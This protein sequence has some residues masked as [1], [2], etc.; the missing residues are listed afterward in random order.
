MKIR[1][2]ELSNFRKFVGTVRVDGIGDGVNVLVGQNELGK[3]TLLEAINGVIFERAKSQ[4]ER[5]RRFRHFVNGT[6]P[7]VELSFDLDGA[8]WTIRKRFAG[9]AGRAQL[10]GPNSRR[11]DDDAAETELQRLLG[12][13]SRRGGGEPGIWATLWVRQGSSF[14]D[15]KL[16]EF[17]RQT[18]EGC[19]EAQVGAVTGGQ[20]GQRIPAAIERALRELQSTRGPSGKFKEAVDRLDA[21]RVRISQLEAKRNEIFG[22]MDR[23]AL[24]RRERREVQSNWDEDTHQ[25]E[26]SEARE[27]QTAAVT[28]A[29]EILAAQNAVELSHERAQRSEIAVRERATL[30]GELE[31]VETEI[32]DLEADIRKVE[33]HKAATQVQLEIAEGHLTDL[34][35]QT[36]LIGEKSRRLERIRGVTALNSEINRHEATL[37]K[38]KELQSQADVLTEAIGRIIATDEAVSRIEA[39]TTELAGA[40]AAVNAVATKVSFTLDRNGLGRVRLNDKSI[41]EIEKAV[42]VVAKTLIGVDDIGVITIEPQIDDRATM[43]ER[44]HLAQSELTV[45]LQAVGADDLSA[46]RAAAA[47]RRELSRQ[48]SD[49][50][51]EITEL[52]PRDVANNLPAGLDARRRRANELRGRLAK[53]MKSLAL[54]VLPT[55]QEIEAEIAAT[56]QEGE[57]LAAGIVTAEAAVGGPRQ[58][59]SETTTSL[60]ALQQR[61]AGLRSTFERNQAT[62][63][64]SRAQHSDDKLSAEAASLS[65]LAAAAQTTLAELQRDQGETVDDIDIRIRRFEAAA[66][67]HLDAVAQLNNDITRLTALIEAN[68]GAGV[69]EA[70]DAACA[71]EEWLKAAVN[72]YKDETAVLQ[73]LRDTLRSA[74]QEAKTLYLEPVVRRTEPYIRML[75]PGAGLVF[76]EH[77]SISA[78]ERSGIQEDF[79]RLSEGTQEQLAV[80]TRLAFAELM[81]D[82]GRPATVILDDALV[83]SDDDRIERMFDILMRAGEKI[84]IIVLTC[85]KRLFTRLGAPML[86]IEEIINDRVPVNPGSRLLIG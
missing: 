60:Q 63:S 31:S 23:L 54:I 43:L 79:G 40:T 61:L 85:R 62:L 30:V 29:A 76:D 49:L 21:V 52:A 55:Y 58:V 5:V 34:R 10:T 6:V 8:R 84:Q 22:Y 4:T 69:E 72:G 25:R 68:E 12:F 74:E 26:L 24:Q 16:D 39:A 83:F 7:E 36:R 81:I 86:Q 50:H 9:Q 48:F 2:V 17:G 3:S 56:H 35:E 28:K 44:V 20:R 11:F 66:R 82:Q 71:E 42:S 45:A 38:A 73:L 18:L 32:R 33:D 65:R 1:S 75:L 14:G 47:E 41:D 80:L 78:V 64:A 46:A 51:R 59:L 13:T 57:E 67:N 15:P 27:R 77:L 19:L 53:E 37:E 70:L